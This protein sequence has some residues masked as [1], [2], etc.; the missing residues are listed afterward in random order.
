MLLGKV[1]TYTGHCSQFLSHASPQTSVGSTD[2]PLP[3]HWRLSF[4]RFALRSKPQHNTHPP[5]L[6][7]TTSTP[8]VQLHLT[9]WCSA[10]SPLLAGVTSTRQCSSSCLD[11][12]GVAAMPLNP[13]CRKAHRWS[14]LSQ[15]N[16]S[17][18]YTRSHPACCWPCQ[19]AAH[20][21]AERQ[22]L[23]AGATTHDRAVV[24]ADGTRHRQ[25]AT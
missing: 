21:A 3:N 14:T 6:H 1:C 18:L 2:Q 23:R 4:A 15:P 11:S 17:Q 8:T 24:A 16:R 13:C 20:T 12:Q 10:F 9:R 25:Q 22:L 7:D 19:R 5:V